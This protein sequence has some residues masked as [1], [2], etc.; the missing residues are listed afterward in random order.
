MLKV[1]ILSF[2]LLFP[3]NQGYAFEDNDVLAPESKLKELKVPSPRVNQ[4]VFINQGEFKPGNILSFNAHYGSAVI[5]IVKIDNERIVS[6]GTDGLFKLWNIKEGKIE[7][8]MKYGDLDLTRLIK[9]KEGLLASGH[10]NGKIKLWDIRKGDLIKEYIIEEGIPIISLVQLEN[11]KIAIGLENG[12]I[13]IMDEDGN[14]NDFPAH[15]GAVNV[16]VL[17]VDGR[18]ASGGQ[19]GKIKIWKKAAVS[20]GVKKEAIMSSGVSDGAPVWKDEIVRVS[21]SAYSPG[22]WKPE[23]VLYKEYVQKDS[24]SIIDLIN[25][26]FVDKKRDK[27]LSLEQDGK[28]V[29]WRI[30]SEKSKKKLRR[31]PKVIKSQYSIPGALGFLELPYVGIKTIAVRKSKKIELHNRTK[32][33]LIDEY[34]GHSGDIKL[35]RKIDDGVIVSADECGGII[36]WDFGSGNNRKIRSSVS[37]ACK[38]DTDLGNGVREGL[39]HSPSIQALSKYGLEVEK[40]APSR[41]TQNYLFRFIYVKDSEKKR[42]LK[43]IEVED[44][45]KNGSHRYIE[46]NNGN[47]RVIDGIDI[48]TIIQKHLDEKFDDGTYKIDVKLLE[49]RVV[50]GKNNHKPNLTPFPSLKETKEENLSKQDLTIAPEFNELWQSIIVKLEQDQNSIAKNYWDKSA[51]TGVITFSQSFVSFLQDKY[52]DMANDILKVIV[53]T[54]LTQ[55]KQKQIS[56]KDYSF[57]IDEEEFKD[58]EVNTLL[59]SWIN[60]SKDNLVKYKSALESYWQYL[61]EQNY[62]DKQ[63]HQSG[64]EAYLS[65][66][67]YVINNH[68]ALCDITKNTDVLLIVETIKGS[69]VAVLNDN[70]IGDVKRLAAA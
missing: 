2:I 7:L 11:E 13:V 66:L 12:K 3:L 53:Q 39:S 15:I 1:V 5:D 42:I 27:L 56:G 58:F 30:P 69:N 38:M 10:K 46:N 44:K 28:I 37:I 64:V 45:A 32:G 43:A 17:M 68:D 65:I 18:I 31:E 70:Q 55:L 36:V 40:N 51:E 49:G 67:D 41:E 59:Y 29:L 21:V 33:S 50:V 22:V 57:E 61:I 16:L 47:I 4:R 6:A 9:L 52:K 62:K 48:N 35:L 19:D 63:D 60:T 54:E 25:L 26:E 14:K 20:S 34:E 24:K 8:E 23:Y